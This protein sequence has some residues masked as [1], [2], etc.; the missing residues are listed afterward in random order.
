MHMCVGRNTR[1]HKGTLVSMAFYSDCWAMMSILVGWVVVINSPP[2]QQR[3]KAVG[4]SELQRSY[5]YN[6]VLWLPPS[7]LTTC[8]AN[9]SFYFLFRSRFHL[10]KQHTHSFTPIKTL[11][12]LP[13]NPQHNNVLPTNRHAKG[14]RRS[15]KHDPIRVQH[16]NRCLE[17]STLTTQ[18]RRGQRS[19]QL[20]HRCAREYVQ[21]GR[22][23]RPIESSRDEQH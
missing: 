13:V 5:L 14:Q 10:A 19:T 12:L 17:R 7:L 4:Q 20:R 15:R 6:T 11:F 9:T 1:R 3:S 16:V 23:Q 8:L 2:W 18:L 22:F 21:K